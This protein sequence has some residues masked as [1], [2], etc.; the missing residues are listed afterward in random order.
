[1][2]PYSKTGPEV[3]AWP[4]L[5]LTVTY[6]SSYP[7]IPPLLDISAPPNAPKNALFN[8]PADK[9]Q[10]L[11]TLEPTIEENMGM[12]M[13]FTLVSTLKDSVEALVA[14]R[15]AAAQ[16]VKDMEVAKAEEE[17]NRKFHGMRVTRESF[18]KWREGFRKEMEDEQRIKEEREGEERKKKGVKDDRLTGKELWERGM[19]GK[20]DEDEE[21]GEATTGM[22]GLKV[23]A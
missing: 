10:L 18:L 7:D 11:A 4:T 17:E 23:G 22:Q 16:A 21:E 8:V 20:V 14:E 6:P 15:A 3:I 12:A 9:E 2:Q 1:L 19:V 5:L 13:V